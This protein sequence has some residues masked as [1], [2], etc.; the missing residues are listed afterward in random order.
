MSGAARD[1]SILR[2]LIL[3]LSARLAAVLEDDVDAAVT[4]ALGLVGSQTG[5]DRAYVMRF[6]HAAGTFDNTH[7]W[8]ADGVEPEREQVQRRP[9]AWMAPWRGAFA[10][11]DAVSI[12]D[13]RTLRGHHDELLAELEAQSIVSVLWVPLPGPRE[14]LGFVGFDA[15]HERPAWSDVEVDLLRSA[16]NVIA[17]ALARV[18]AVVERDRVSERLRAVAELVPGVVYQYLVDADGRSSYPYVSPGVTTLMGVSPAAL[19]ESGTA[20]SE[21]IHPDDRGR[22]KVASATSMHDLSTWR[23]EFRVRDSNERWRWVRGMARPRRLPD[24]ATLWHGVLVDVT[25]EHALAEALRQRKH[26]LA[27]ITETLRDVVVLTDADLTVRYVSPSV[28]EVLGYD[29]EAVV[30]RRVTEFLHPGEIEIAERHLANG[31]RDRDGSTLVHRMLHADGSV[32]Y[33]ESLIHVLEGEGAVFSAR[34]VTER[35]AYQ[36]RLE[37]EVA[38]RGA[39]VALTN[40][41]L[42][43]TLDEGFYQQV[44]EQAIA[45]VPDAEGAAC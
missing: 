26:D 3:A 36:Q 8:V 25:E 5:A 21:R 43:D 38:F 23:T 19:R 32:R 14:P 37:R 13:V 17:G 24:G 29:P 6:D 2:D 12:D 16:A 9:L 1:E 41:M 40:D 4:E 10:M 42:A 7:E 34:D 15:V 18:D 39:L 28:Q 11:G 22:L 33:F 45:L 20:A 31:F 30:G 35:V 44:L 27:R